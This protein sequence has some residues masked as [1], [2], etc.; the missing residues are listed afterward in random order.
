MFIRLKIKNYRKISVFLSHCKF[1][2]LES[3]K[4]M[5]VFV[6]LQGPQEMLLPSAE[7]AKGGADAL[8]G[9]RCVREL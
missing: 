8:R 3:L 2:I 7:G 1:P 6:F 4:G 5:E 9:S